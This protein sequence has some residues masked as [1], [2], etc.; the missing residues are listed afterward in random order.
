MVGLNLFLHLLLDPRKVLGRD[1]VR[2]ID[3]VIEAIVDRRTGGKLRFR[4]NAQHRRGQHMRAGMTQRF[5]VSHGLGISHGESAGTAIKSKRNA[6]LGNQQ[7]DPIADGI[8]HIAIL[9]NQ[10]RSDRPG[11]TGTCT[12]ELRLV[13]ESKALMR[14]RAA[15]KFQQTGIHY[16]ITF[17]LRRELARKMNRPGQAAHDIGAKLMVIRTSLLAAVLPALM[18]GFSTGVETVRVGSGFSEPVFL[19]YTPT[20]PDKVFVVE[21]SGTIKILDPSSGNATTFLRVENINTTNENGLLGLA[22]HPDYATTG[23]FYVDVINAAGIP[24]FAN[25]AYRHVPSSRIPLAGKLF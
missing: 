20:D 24:K 18:S 14:D 15:N 7:R 10:A 16:E 12:D 6:L 11:R 19:T 23:K 2:Q 22:F 13:S 17:R 4:P 8:E 9:S 21:K 1:P 3:V 25:T 5:D